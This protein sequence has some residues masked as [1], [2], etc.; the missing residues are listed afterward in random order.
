[1]K[2]YCI[3]GT[4]GRGIFSYAVPLIEDFSDC[5]ELCGVYDINP[6][7]AALVSEYVKKPIPVYDSFDAMIGACSPTPSSSP[8]RTA[9]TPPTPCA[10][11]SWA[12]TSSP[13]SP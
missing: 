7:R 11:W 3:V 5:A 4:G 12:A 2:K 6:K 13:K 8:P 1:M 10:P 9:S